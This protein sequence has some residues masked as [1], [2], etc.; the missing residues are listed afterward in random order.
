MS[1]D[2]DH[3][4]QRTVA[5][6]L[7][8]HGDSGATGRRR[9]RRAADDVPGE[10]DAPPPGHVTGTFGPQWQ[11]TAEPDRSMLRERVPPAQSQPLRQ[12]EREPQPWESDQEPRERR[13]REA[14]PWESSSRD[15]PSWEPQPR[16]PLPRES[17]ESRT[18]DAQSPKPQPR[19]PQ[20]P[21]M[22][23]APPWE[24]IKRDTPP[25]EARPR[26]PQP[27]EAQ[28]PGPQ[29]RVREPQQRDPL[30]IDPLPPREP[31]QPE[32]APR[33]PGSRDPLARE[34]PPREP[35]RDSRP[36]EGV[37]W[38]PR[39]RDP[40]PPPRVDRDS[41]VRPA[42]PVV[43]DR[44]APVVRER[45]TELI[46]PVRDARSGAL[47]APAPG[48]GAP[49]RPGARPEFGAD[50]DSG[51]AT[52]IGIAPAGAEA[53]HHDRTLERRGA[54][55]DDGGPPTEAAAPLDFD[56]PAGLG[57]TDRED[58]DGDADYHGEP[59]D[60]LD[61]DDQDGE[62]DDAGERAGRRQRLPNL[63]DSAGQ[64]WAAVVAQWIVGAIGGAA[65][66]VGFRF[67]WR[68]LP[69][70]ALAA[71]VLVT[72]GLVV[73]VRALLRNNDMRTTLFAVLVGLL[74]TVSPALLVLLGR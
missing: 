56:H 10:D 47:D 46:A 12:P 25:R 3:P 38:E 2:T 4:R 20:Q 14:P 32:A 71:A 62:P 27:W 41:E 57:R 22:R 42:P 54:P 64:V 21:R 9:R 68:G 74:L 63:A 39:Q 60:D 55:A 29:A 34:F 8:A 70:V 73:I 11:P 28:S 15:A 37:T 19:E 50:G 1:S 26:E 53:W 7:A 18:R 35:Q 36:R 5:E 17:W 58:F 24:S 51:P 49:P 48:R 61:H 43:R 69:V 65:L 44:P 33:Q 59:E 45:P 23:E 31:R 67:L 30:G 52:E 72:A 66:W 6:L 40:L 16:E 13:A